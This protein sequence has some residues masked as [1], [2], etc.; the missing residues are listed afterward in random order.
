MNDK[1]YIEAY[2]K[3]RKKIHDTSFSA[4]PVPYE[5]FTLPTQVNGEW[6]IYCEIL[7]DLSRQLA[8]DINQLWN[9]IV[10]LEAWSKVLSSSSYNEKEKLY[11]LAEFIKPLAVVALNLPHAIRTRFI[12]SLSH[13]CHQPNLCD[14]CIKKRLYL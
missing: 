2:A 4:K 1:F 8:N 9:D 14:F 7:K 12:F 10:K 3:Y 6:F 13:I 11:L 5:W